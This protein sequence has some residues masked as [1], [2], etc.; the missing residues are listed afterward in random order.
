M[1]VDPS[2]L[3]DEASQPFECVPP[4][5][6]ARLSSCDPDSAERTL[7]R[8]DRCERHSLGSEGE[9]VE[10]PSKCASAPDS[11]LLRALCRRVNFDQIRSNPVCFLGDRDCDVV[12]EGVLSV[13]SGISFLRLRS[14]LPDSGV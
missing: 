14:I 8:G 4:L 1:S 12:E 7:G 13:E 9:G 2:R 5:L 6:I 3:G 11:V 10:A